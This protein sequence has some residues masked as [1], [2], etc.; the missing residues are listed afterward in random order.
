VVP[1]EHPENQ[2][3]GEGRGGAPQPERVDAGIEP[4][5][6]RLRRLAEVQPGL[7]E[8]PTQAVGETG[9]ARRGGELYAGAQRGF[10]CET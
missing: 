10:F 1:P 4:S 6:D 7:A 2:R 8:G 9:D 5:R 3:S